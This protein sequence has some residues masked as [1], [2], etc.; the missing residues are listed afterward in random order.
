[1]RRLWPLLLIL[2]IGTLSGCAFLQNLFASAFQKPTLQFRNANLADV[3]LLGLT[4]NLNFALNNPNPIA[5]SLAEVDY[6]LFV[7]GRQVVAGKPPNGL[8]IPA[9]QTANLVFPAQIQFAD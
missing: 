5:L 1:M 2:G 4:L 8:N 7:E 6:A 9:N 3:G